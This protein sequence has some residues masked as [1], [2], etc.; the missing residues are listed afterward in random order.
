MCD[1][2][3]E[4][5]ST[6]PARKGQ[7]YVLDRFSTGSKGFTTSPGCG[8][9]VCIP[10][11]SRLH[12]EGIADDVQRRYGIGP[13]EDA[14]MGHFEVGRYRDAVRFSNGQE[15]LLQFLN[16]GVTATVV[17]L[18]GDVAVDHFEIDAAKDL[19]RAFVTT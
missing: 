8:T 13:K 4:S 18:V 2:S 17:E 15:V 5:F 16:P 1:Y 9:A 11:D 12:I 3:L 14:T 10:A 7:R 6:L 19:R